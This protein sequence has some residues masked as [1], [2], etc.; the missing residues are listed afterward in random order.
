M[1]FRVIFAAL[2]LNLA[3][4]PAFANRDTKM[5][6]ADGFFLQKGDSAAGEKAF[7]DLK[8]FACHT[9]EN[10]SEFNTPA[11]GKPAPM[12]G[13]KQASYASG[14]IADSIVSPSHRLAPDSYAEVENDELP[15]MPDFTDTLTIR[16]MMDLVAYIKS[17]GEEAKKK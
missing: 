7:K 16:Q 2:F 13:K 12:L 1:I 11:L 8:C 9:V 4:T 15:I 17:L 10:S 6:P 3:V 5:E 14:W